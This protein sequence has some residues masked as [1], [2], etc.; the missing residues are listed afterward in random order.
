MEKDRISSMGNYIINQGKVT[1]KELSN[2]FNISIVTVRRDLDKLEKNNV[3]TKIYGGAKAK[4][5]KLQTFE[6]RKN[7]NSD[8]KNH[9]IN[10]AKNHIN[11][12]DRIFI[13][14]GTTTENLLN[15]L[16]EN[17]HLT[18]FTNNLSVINRAAIMKN[19][20]LFVVG[21]YYNKTSNSFTYWSKVST[22]E[23]FNINKAFMCTSGLTIKDG[24]TN[25]N[26]IEQEIKSKMC[27]LSNK[28]YL[29]IDDSKIG[30][31]SLMTYAKLSDIDVLITNKH[32]NQEYI[33]YLNEHNIKFEF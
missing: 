16:D 32:I 5:D 21:D 27:R 29:L 22:L 28:I 2:K 24:L 14:S 25:K 10:L 12:G 8:S 15:Y 18:V 6:Q 13:D 26:P 1:T 4:S 11:N 17:I 23:S 7:L 3:I 19:V 33:D 9:I 31:T 30:K 20:N